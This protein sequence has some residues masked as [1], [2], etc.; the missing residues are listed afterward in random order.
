M[1]S[2]DPALDLFPLA[3]SILAAIT[4]GVLGNFLLLRRESLMGDAI[5]HGVLPGLVIGFLLT[6]DRS[7]LTMLVGATVA[8]IATI[9]LVMVV[10]RLGRVEPG[11]AMGV[12]FSVLFALGVLLI[13][14]AAR[15]TDIDADCVLHGQLETLAWY[16]APTLWRDVPAW[17]TIQSMPRQVWGLAIACLLAV[18]FVI[19]FFKELRLAAF[20]PEL[21]SSLGLRP[22]AIEVATMVL[23]A[24]ATV[25]SFEAVGSI[26][27]IAMLICPAATAR[28]LTDRLS[29]QVI[30]SVVV[31]ITTTVLGYRAATIVPSWIDGESVN[32]AGSMAVTAGFV[33]IVAILA[34]PGHGVIS[35]HLRARRLARKI[36]I[37]D[38]LA[39]L[40][41]T[42]EARSP[43]ALPASP[44]NLHRIP[45]PAAIERAR[46]S[47]L[48]AGHLDSDLHLTDEG[49]R[50][51][52]DVLRRHRLWETY[53]VEE[54][55][56]SPDHVHDPAE[57]LE[58][59]GPMPTI[60]S[61]RDPHGRMIPGNSKQGVDQVDRRDRNDRA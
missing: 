3:A 36:A 57:V 5:S 11:A 39:T 32:A 8:G 16:D 25:A 6:G 42:E 54:A 56:L 61:T 17:T 51:T 31:A 48:I 49:R 33:L 15:Q 21:A 29:R 58:H 45:D 59:L 24:M 28:L 40:L 19:T 18:G 14:R 41:R 4:C 55:G 37:D 10:R 26:L 13:E 60:L 43:D 44:T 27:V 30:L 47:G 52:R 9:L 38:L 50:T 2:L 7:P 53:L 46:R 23:V 22:R 1:T 35:R 12:V 20:D 34:S